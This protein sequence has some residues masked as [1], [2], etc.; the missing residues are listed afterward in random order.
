MEKVSFDEGYFDTKPKDELYAKCKKCGNKSSAKDFKIDDDLGVM[1]CS[2]CFHS[3]GVKRLSKGKEKSAEEKEVIEE[4]PSSIVIYDER[5]ALRAEAKEKR[6][7]PKPA[8]QDD[9]IKYICDK[10]G[11]GFKYN[12]IKMW[13]RVCPAC[14]RSIEDIKEG[15]RTISRF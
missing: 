5:D 7:V 2:N 9:R 11:F 13:P 3:S 4:K 12:P 6:V 8:V 1:V 14:A 15:R 10:C